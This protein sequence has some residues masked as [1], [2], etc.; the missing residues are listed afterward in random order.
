MAKNTVVIIA[1]VLAIISAFCSWTSIRKESLGWYLAT[2]LFALTSL[3]F[4][5]FGLFG[6]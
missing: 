1:V 6:F 4:S 5:I 3:G 2:T